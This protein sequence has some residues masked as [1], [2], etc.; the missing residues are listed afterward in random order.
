MMAWARTPYGDIVR[1]IGGGVFSSRRLVH[2]SVHFFPMYIIVYPIF[3]FLTVGA[4]PET[5]FVGGLSGRTR[6]SPSPP[7]ASCPG[8]CTPWAALSWPPRPLLRQRS[9]ESPVEESQTVH[10]RGSC[11]LSIASRICLFA[12][13]FPTMLAPMGY[14]NAICVVC[15]CACTPDGGVLIEAPTPHTNAICLS[16][17]GR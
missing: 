4:R 5:P 15:S 12:L 9:R 11:W 10:S 7:R 1:R 13:V 3:C 8:K 6:I 2:N 17:S 16:E 14:L